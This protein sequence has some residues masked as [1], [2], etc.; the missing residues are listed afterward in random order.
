MIRDS[1]NIRDNKI[2]WRN[3]HVYCDSIQSEMEFY[4]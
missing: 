1:L 3:W 2:V 4:N